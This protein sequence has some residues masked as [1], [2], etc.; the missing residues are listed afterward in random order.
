MQ[1]N[2]HSYLQHQK[3]RND[4]LQ[5]IDGEL[6]NGRHSLR[7]KKFRSGVLRRNVTNNSRVFARRR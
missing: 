5:R 7:F 1:K 3:Q 4:V 6:L 2:K